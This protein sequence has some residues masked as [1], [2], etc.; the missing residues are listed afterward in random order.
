METLAY[1]TMSRREVEQLHK[2]VGL[3]GTAVLA[4]AE[5]VSAQRGD[6]SV[7]RRV[8]AALRVAAALYRE[9][10]ARFGTGVSRY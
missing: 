1:P 5:P 7:L 8:V 3:P 6:P 2:R 10:S 9:A 4:P